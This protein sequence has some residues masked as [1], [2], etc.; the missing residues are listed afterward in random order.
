MATKPPT[1]KTT[2]RSSSPGEEPAAPSA[3]KTTKKATVSLI[4]E[5]GA[6][7][8]RTG[9][10]KTGSAF[11]PLGAKPAAKPAPAAKAAPAPAAPP[12][13]TLDQVKAE[14]LNLFDE[15]ERKAEARRTRREEAAAAPAPAPA[16]SILPPISL[17][18]E[19]EPKPRPVPVAAP[20]PAPAPAPAPQLTPVAVEEASDPKVI[21]LKPPIIVRDLAERMGLKTFNIIKDLMGFQVFAKADTAVEPEIASKVCELHGFT[22]EKEKREKGAGVHKVEEKIVEPPPP[23]PPK[24]E[25]KD[26]FELRAPIITFMGHVDHG[27][28]SL[29]DAVRKS[30][31]VKGEA[32]GITQHIGAYSVFYNDRPI[33]FIDTPGHAA[34]SEMR[35]RG[36]D[37]TDIVVLV[38]AA[39]DGFMPQTIEAMNHAKAA[40]VT[41]MV[42][43]NKVDLPA[44][45]PMRV[46][47][48]LQEHGLMPVEWGGDTEVLEV[49][50]TKGIGLDNLLE[51]MSLQAEVLDLRAN[52]K[53][54]MRAT[55]IESRMDPGRGPTATAIVQNGTLKVGEPFICGPYWG[56]VKNLINDFGKPIK[57]V[58]PGMP[59]EVIGFSGMPNVG[60]EIVEMDNER[61][62]KRLSE[63]RQEEIRQ[64]KLAAPRRSTLET[65]FA[66]IEEGAKKNL[67]IVL[68]TDVQGSLEAIIKA[69]KEIKSDK[70]EVKVLHGAAGPISEGDILLASASD[71][72]VVG[73][74][75]KVENTAVSI[76][77]REGVQVKLF[78]II[79]ELLDQMKEAMLGL[80]DPETREKV[81]GHA[82]VKQVFKLSRGI[83][84]GCVVTDGRVDR[85]ARARVLR[86][87]TPVYD[88]AMDTLRRFQDEV[89]EVRNGLECGIRLAGYRE[90]QEDDVIEVYELEKFQ[91]TL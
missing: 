83:V 27:K 19:E 38:I 11:T 75:V 86:G 61:S 91:Q 80:L 18:R 46:K 81:I 41:I 71:A 12:K 52:P 73:F 24:E 9:E 53:A 8:K 30:S 28:T 20:K 74:N 44:A 82:R 72:V 56:K 13:K 66:N 39:D 65:L 43:I 21:H 90:Y 79:Y 36:A 78:S 5:A 7:K 4:D 1:S 34:F 57:A 55:V 60:D 76:A 84:A 15:E 62:A 85:K 59:A 45:N 33:T 64:K 29:M 51:T 69:L 48:Q 37:I 67:N 70:V 26:V 2:K 63:E 6:K 89:P 3:E 42:A 25:E 14:A 54:P 49:S 88:G 58:L 10:L 68:K 40:K 23:E 22:F 32:G 17:L 31:V 77:K 35:A 87:T 47:Q 50:A 16:S